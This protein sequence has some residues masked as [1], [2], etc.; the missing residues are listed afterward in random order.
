M[1]S[2]LADLDARLDAAG[3]HLARYRAAGMRVFATSSFQPNS[4]LLLHLLA[5]RAPWVPVYFLDTGYHFPETLLWRDA[6]ARQTG[7][8]VVDL[9]S[10]MPRSQQR[11]GE[12]RLL[13]VSDPDRCCHLNKV[14][15]L[16]PV[17]AGHDV[18]VTGV[19]ATQSAQRAAMDEEEP[20]PSGI[21]KYNPLL[22]WTGAEVEALR[23]ARDLP[24]HPL[25]GRGYASVGCAPC[26]TASGGG[27]DDRGGRWSGQRKTECGLHGGA[28]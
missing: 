9:R 18:W 11:D 17:Q 26:T 27:L 2:D 7:L 20:D 19:R 3:A 22:R 16:L 24:R 14:L 10:P 21:L 1:S 6:V 15:P 25:E 5:S 23:A 28:R 4:V 12:G 8:R 13:F